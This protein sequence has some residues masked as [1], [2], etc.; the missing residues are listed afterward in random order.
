MLTLLEMNGFEVLLAEDGHQA[1]ARAKEGDVELALVDVMM[2]GMDGLDC[3]RLLKGLFPESFL[4]IV[5]LTARADTGQA[6]SQGC[7]SA[8][9]ST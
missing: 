6:A 5:L 7:A 4:P 9:T 8:P 3:C 1:V 2:P